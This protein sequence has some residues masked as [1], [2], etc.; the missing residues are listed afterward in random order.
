MA[1][2]TQFG[3]QR[4]TL[5]EILASMK[6][7]LRSKLGEDWNVE[8]GSVEDQF[9]SVFAEEA[10]QGWQGLEGIYSSQTLDGAEGIYLDDVLSRQGVYRK[11]RTASS[12]RAVVFSNYATVSVG[13]TISN[14]ATV[15]ASNTL[16][17]NVLSSVTI[18]N[19]MACYKLAASQIT[20]GVSYT[21]ALYNTRSPNNETFTWTPT[22]DSDKDNMLRGLVDFINEGI[23]DKPNQA[24]YNAQ[25]RTMYVGFDS[26]TN[27]PQPFD[28][29]TLYVSATP[30]VGSLGHVLELRS[31]TLGFN[32]LTPNGLINL[33]P[34]YTGYES[35]V[36]GDDFNS[37]SEVQTDAEYRLSAIN[38]KDSSIA[39][40]PDS[41]ISNLLRI[42]GVVDAE[43]Y[44]NPTSQF[45]YDVSGNTVVEPF[46][47]NVAVLGG[48]DN[49]VAQVILD[50][51][52]G[53]TRRFGTYSANAINTKGQSVSVNFT[54]VGYFD[55]EVEVGYKAKDNTPL[56]ETEKNSI[57]RNLATTASELRIGDT[58]PRSLMEAVTFQSVSFSRLSQVSV[59]LRDLTEVGSQFT[60]DDIAADYDEK[61]RVLLDKVIFK[62]I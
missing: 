6:L 44:E 26:S 35:I 17:Y 12:G 29:G 23:L 30:R 50:R 25:L 15:S 43:V 10:D 28:K 42:E 46:T 1:G 18:D 49:E 48:D 14:T 19:Y 33:S 9:I 32:P 7:N 41:I 5:P 53:N 62:R 57:I 22:T 4:K 34:T 3:F 27:L 47:Y 20:V 8:T 38:I 16:T 55:V 54:R 56:T 36:N 60:S 11:G 61:P 59:R 58:V 24:Y 31:D 52:Y 45:I 39:G 40:T 21:L 2:L 37:G 51:G 13:R